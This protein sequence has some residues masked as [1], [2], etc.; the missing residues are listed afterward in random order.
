[1]S[2]SRLMKI[3]VGLLVFSAVSAMASFAYLFYAEQVLKPASV[4]SGEPAGQIISVRNDVRRRSADSL[5]WSQAG[6]QE[7]VNYEDSIFTGEASEA[8]IESPG[9]GSILLEPKSLVVIEKRA[10]QVSLDLQVGSASVDLAAGEKVAI[11]VGGKEIELQAQSEASSIRLEKTASDDLKIA[12]VAGELT[13]ISA[14]AQETVAPGEQLNVNKAAPNEKK[15]IL[16]RLV[17]P[18]PNSTVWLDGQERPTQFRWADVGDSKRKYRF[19]VARDSRFRDVVADQLVTGWSLA[20]KLPSDTPLFWRV[21]PEGSTEMA[22]AAFM[23]ASKV[24]PALTFPPDDYRLKAK[25][26]RTPVRFV[27]EGRPGVKQY[28]I[29]VASTPDFS[30]A[31]EDVEVKESKA[32]LQLPQAEKLYW[33]VSASGNTPIAGLW[34]AGR[35]LAVLAPESEHTLVALPKADAAALG[36]ATPDSLPSDSVAALGS[37]SR[38]I[39]D[40]S[41]EATPSPTP[42][43]TATPTPTPTPTPIPT[44]TPTPTPVPT[45]TP[46]PPPLT[47]EVAKRDIRGNLKWGPDGKALNWPV[48][49]WLPS[50]R[51]VKY[52]LQ[53]ADDEKFERVVLDTSF[54]EAKF[55]WKDAVI[56]ERF[57]RARAIGKTGLKSNFTQPGRVTV[58]TEPPELPARSAGVMSV[59]R[60]KELE[61]SNAEIDFAWKPIPQSVRYEV[62]V[63]SSTSFENAKSFKSEKATARL[64]V[65]TKGNF[66]RVRA[67]DGTGKA[68]SAFSAPTQLSV[69]KK[70]V[71]DPPELVQPDEDATVVAL[72]KGEGSILFSWEP[73]PDA[74]MY[75]MQVSLDPAFTKLVA[76][77]QTPKERVVWTQNMAE[78]KYYWRVRSK[79]KETMSDWT[80]TRIL[81]IE[82]RPAP[83]ARVPSGNALPPAKK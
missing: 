2:K 56:G 12:P 40:V 76:S 54:E 10:G 3:E 67:L 9:G 22:N 59:K 58:G 39:A 23:T 24:A 47:P 20:A 81:E 7:T 80:K 65:T 50:A 75:D 68:A 49:E 32:K 13:T 34:S 4:S 38:K 11:A 30:Q 53:V 79:Y 43:P 14:G 46:E 8:I 69:S 21:M 60:V 19:V 27:W 31:I 18:K 66:V 25:G 57:W 77:R 29:Q 15:K 61:A 6:L 62:Q 83:K 48:M 37:G 16:L 63:A 45:A 51:A 17:E 82:S 74:Q 28:R 70:L 26:E 78:G 35:K 42:E 1:M 64:P 55:R 5:I 72:G 33:R 52:Q 73:T 44:P 71:F 41:I 36:P